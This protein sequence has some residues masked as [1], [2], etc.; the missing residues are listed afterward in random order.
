M[1]LPVCLNVSLN[2][3]Y[4]LMSNDYVE[5]RSLEKNKSFS[6]HAR[7]DVNEDRNLCYS[8]SSEASQTYNN[9]KCLF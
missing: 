5:T 1:F 9:C 4:L 6:I 7:I 2:G 3:I 8:I